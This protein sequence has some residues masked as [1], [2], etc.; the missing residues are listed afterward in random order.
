MARVRNASNVVAQWYP[1]LLYTARPLA[2]V[3]L[4]RVTVE[5]QGDRTSD[6]A[7]EV[8]DSLPGTWCVLPAT[9]SCSACEAQTLDWSWD[10]NS[11]TNLLWIPNRGKMPPNDDRM[12][13]F[14]ARAL[15]AKVG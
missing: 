15:A 2:V 9:G 14:A 10:G 7:L 4:S 8:Q 1:R 13:L 12:K 5:T 6:C 3:M 11:S